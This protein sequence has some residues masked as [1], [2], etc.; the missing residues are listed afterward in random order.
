MSAMGGLLFGYDWVVI[1]NLIFT[2]VA[3]RV[4]DNWGR[5][6]LMLFGSLGLAVIYFILG[7]SYVLEVKGLIVLVLVL[8]AIATYAMTLAP[9]TWVVLSEIFPN[10]VRGVAMAMATNALIDQF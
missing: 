6:R 9:I 10:R 8:M 3:M 5:R 7:A 1:V 2:L 4:V